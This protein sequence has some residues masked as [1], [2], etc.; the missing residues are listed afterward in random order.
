MI[1]VSVRFCLNNIFLKSAFLLLENLPIFYIKRIHS[2]IFQ[3]SKH[4][5]RKSSQRYIKRSSGTLEDCGNIF[6]NVFKKNML[7]FKMG[8][9]AV[10]I[11]VEYGEK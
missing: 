9:Y 8:L 5:N 2:L 4:S 3:N 6:K 10:E 11:L 7:H 1:Q